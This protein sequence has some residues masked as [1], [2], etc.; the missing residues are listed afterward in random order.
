MQEWQQVSAATY[1]LEVPGGWLYQ[2]RKPDGV[3]LTFVPHPPAPI[4][5]SSTQY[6]PA[7]ATGPLGGNY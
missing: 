4:N 1:R 2:V 3:A 5:W 7:Y 6:T